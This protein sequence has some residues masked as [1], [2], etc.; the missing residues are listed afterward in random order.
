VIRMLLSLLLLPAMALAAGPI[1]L[2][3]PDGQELLLESL[4]VRAAV[5][6]MLSLTE[7][8]M[9]FRSP[10]QDISE[11]RFTCVLPAGA[12]ISRFAKEVGGVLMEG[13]VVERMKANRIY[14]EI[15][16]EMRD[17]ALLEQ[18]LGNRFS[19]RIFPIDPDGRVRLIL[20]WTQLVPAVDGVRTLVIPL[21]GLPRVASFDFSAILTPLPGEGDMHVVGLGRP[22]IASRHLRFTQRD[23]LPE[24]VE[25]D[26]EAGREGLQVLR[27]GDYYLASLVPAPEPEGVPQ[28]SAPASW[29]VYVDTSASSASGLEQRLG[30]LSEILASLPP[31][32]AIE[33]MA[34]DQ[35]IDRLFDGSAGEAGRRIESALR[36]RKFLGGTDIEAVVRDIATRAKGRWVVFVSDGVATQGRTDLR[37]LRDVVAVLPPNLSLNAVVLGATQSAE[38]L[39]ELTRGR[40]RIVEVPFTTSMRAH[41]R[42]AAAL[43]QVPMGARA[44]VR[45]EAAE[46]FFPQLA[47]DVRPRHEV[48][49]VG[50]VSEGREP[51]IAFEGLDSA[52]FAAEPVALRNG[53]F[54]TLLEREA[55]RAYLQDLR[56]REAAAADELVRAALVREQVRISIER[57]ILVPRTTL[58]VLES[59]DDYKRYELDRRS[60][61]SILTVGGDGID[62]I[63]RSAIPAHRPRPPREQIY[64]I[65]ESITIT[66][67]PA[68]EIQ[69]GEVLPEDDG[70]AEDDEREPRSPPRR[71]ASDRAEGG[72]APAGSSS[73]AEN[74][75]ARAATPRQ[76]WAGR[77]EISG[78]R[79]EALFE[80][81]DG[82]P[83]DRS[84]YNDLGEAL[85][86][87]REWKRLAALAQRWQPYD[88]ENPQVYELLMEAALEAGSRE[89]AL[90]AAGSLAEIAPA[91]P[92]LLQ[93]AGLLLL[94]IAETLAPEDP[95]RPHAMRLALAPLRRAVELRPDRANAH[96]HLALALWRAGNHAEAAGVLERATQREYPQWYGNVHRVLREELGWI[97]R[98]W[99]AEDPARSAD[100]ALRAERHEV[101]LDRTDALRITLAWDTDANDVDLH[102]ID[103]GGEECWY[104][105]PKTTTLELYEDITQGFGPEVI[106][107]E[108][109]LKGSYHI[110]VKYY[111]EGPMGI[112][113]G[114]VLVLQP[115]RS[116]R[117]SLEIIPF[118]LV[119]GG[120]E[121]QVRPI[122]VIK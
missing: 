19:A 79:V 54:E 68:T 17:P 63:A 36:T 59:E 50:K 75:S 22:T 66:A 103:P 27:A 9:E 4:S 14:D 42:A 78:Q 65:A 11:G 109:R 101:D 45:D 34:F 108:R 113:R 12:T 7:L 62:R 8:E 97:Y 110:G 52:A 112:A 84:I 95:D 30:A 82:D 43:L 99:R 114:V 20:S 57:R 44:A 80:E 121:D 76:S 120:R 96:R 28:S 73:V 38:T 15:L 16:H 25:L 6:G 31:G 93:R 119:Q 115:T 92:E 60:L 48:I 61:E 40:G 21:R 18:D 51:A 39:R 37:D 49:V 107:A 5:H 10:R 56:E 86:E 100:I 104:S 116:A 33:I 55:Y 88:P 94:R 29:L 118:R 58:L 32:D 24:D 53:S 106:R 3:D 41:A 26:R 2:S 47:E 122:A 81:L 35:T 74:I 77:V 72:M 70:E 91:K 117:P 69:I 89:E 98:D 67:P 46:W 1:S 13:E 71:T 87:R 23:W 102:V 105:E 90:R 111:D 83:L 64:A 85:L